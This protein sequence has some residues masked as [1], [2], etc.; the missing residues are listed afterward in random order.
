MKLRHFFFAALASVMAFAACEQEVDPV[1]PDNTPEIYTVKL[2]CT[3]EI[4]VNQVPLRAFTPGTN[5]LYGIQVYYKPDSASSSTKYAYYAYGL[6]DDISNVTIDLIANY[7][8][9]IC[10]DLIV[11]GKNQV[12][13]DGVEIES[14]NYTGYGYPFQAYN[15]YEGT[16]DLSITKVTNDFIYSTDCYFYAL[17][18]YIQLPGTTNN[19]C[20]PSGV[21][22][23]YGKVVDFVPA[24]DTETI[25]IFMKRMVYGLKVI[26][27]DFL[28]EGKVD[29]IREYASNSPVY[30]PDFTLTPDNKEV[31]VTYL[32]NYRDEWYDYE[33]LEDAY[34]YNEITF[35]WTKD[36]GTMLSL[37][38][39]RIRFNRLKQTIV[40][41]TFYEDP[42]I[43]DVNL[44][45]QY[46]DQVFVEGGSYTFGDDQSEYEF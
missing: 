37:L 30:I 34:E 46:E 11:D 28:T 5:D 33:E 4:D 18:E 44:T 22:G 6:F 32:H 24:S 8:F 43:E 45:V 14:V 21:D 23:Y 3:G 29:V 1:N 35:R 27:G 13:S 42:T 26:A 17:G 16:R 40:N 31:E 10:V 19:R 9:K 20:I 39:Q 15:N 2:N 38:P 36:D 25:S 12:Y 41:V 7:K